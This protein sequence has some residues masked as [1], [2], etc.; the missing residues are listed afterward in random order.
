[1]NGLALD[2]STEVLSVAASLGSQTVSVTRIGPLGHGR[3]LAQI[4][5]W[6]LTRLGMQPAELDYVACA[7]GPGSFTGLR[8]GMAT[9]KGIAAGLDA[10]PFPLVSVPTLELFAA[11]A[12]PWPGLVIPVIDAKKARF[13]SGAFRNGT[14]LAAD[15]DASPEVIERMA[16]TLRSSVDEPMLLCGPHARALSEQLAI[17]H[18]VRRSRSGVATVLLNLAAERAAGGEFDQPDAGP[19]YLRGSDARLPTA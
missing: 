10:H 11:E 8:I 17:T 6:C 5:D 9:A 12:A 19:A 15:V 13:Y 7:R 4:I 1:M 16:E 14:R 18:T 2:T 3:H